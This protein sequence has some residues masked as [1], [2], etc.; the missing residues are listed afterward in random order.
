MTTETKSRRK[1]VY[2][3]KLTHPTYKSLFSP[4]SKYSVLALPPKC[5]HTE[6]GRTIKTSFVFSFFRSKWLRPS[7]CN[8][9]GPALHGKMWRLMGPPVD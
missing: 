9:E 1:V 3:T 8:V 2:F 7:N 4:N 5:G 6:P